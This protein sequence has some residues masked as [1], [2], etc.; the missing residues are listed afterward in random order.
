MKLFIEQRTYA[1]IPTYVFKAETALEAVAN[2]KLKEDKDSQHSAR[3]TS[4]SRQVS[5]ERDKVQSKLEFATAL[6]HLGQANYEK[7][8]FAFVN[9]GSADKLGDWVGKV[10]LTLSCSARSMS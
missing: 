5:G 3:Q 1:Q 2:S 10:R 7:A 9:L 6:A 8:A 4:S